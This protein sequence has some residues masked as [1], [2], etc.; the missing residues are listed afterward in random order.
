MS[1][2]LSDLAESKIRQLLFG[3][4]LWSGKPT[5]FYLA[6]LTAAPTDAGGGTEVSGKGYLRKAVACDS[7]NWYVSDN[8]VINATA[9]NF[10]A[11]ATEPWES[12]SHFAIYSAAARG[13]LLFWGSL[14]EVKTIAKYGTA[15]F[16]AGEI[17]ISLGGGFGL[18]AA[19]RVLK[20]LF[21]AATWTAT[22]TLYVGLGTNADAN[23][24]WG[25]PVAS[26]GGSATAYLRGTYANTTAKWPAATS[27]QNTTSNAS[28][29]TNFVA[30][31]A[32]WGNLTHIGLLNGA[33]TPGATYVQSSA[34]IV[35]TAPTAHGL[36][37]ARAGFTAIAATY[38]RSGTTVIVTFAQP[39]PFS[40]GERV[41]LDFTSGGAADATYS[42]TAATTLTITF[43]TAASGTIA[44]GS[45]CT[46]NKV[47]VADIWF[48][49]TSST[50]PVSRRYYLANL[51]DA[52][53]LGTPGSDPTTKFTVV[54][55]ADE[56]TQ[57]VT[58]SACAFS[59][60]EVIA[61][62]ALTQA[63]TI[64]SGDTTSVP[65]A[66]LTAAFD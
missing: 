46:V 65:T 22:P 35:V 28:G 43:D 53:A 8:Q 39:H 55:A 32:D 18:L 33:I 9:L 17:S 37:I 64:N 56:T 40:T 13:D 47:T 25:E 21:N 41:L 4:A 36:T 57:T 54:A 31:T 60:A 63:I 23:Q 62:A 51:G 44:A 1:T 16:E 20:Y 7:T 61:F 5:T 50:Y 2:S 6:L 10:S 19:Y 11:T 49:A 15:S 30:A 58:S 14:K 42:I 26:S 24:V 48:Q 59:T 29:I 52:T 27:A 66:G 3:N 34:N 38:E 12:V 45:T